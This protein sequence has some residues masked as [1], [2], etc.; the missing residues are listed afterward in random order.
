MRDFLQCT[1]LIT[2]AS[3]G[4]GW[5]MAR[6]LA[7]RAAC[8]ILAARRL[9]R[10]EA[11]KEELLVINPE[12][13]VELHQVDL[14]DAFAL[15]LFTEKLIKSQTNLDFLINN[16]GLG[17]RGPFETSEWEKIDKVLRVNVLALT[18][19]CHQLIPLLKR[20]RPGAIL[21]VSSIA[22]QLPVPDMGVYAATKAYVSSFSETLRAE[23]R[24]T[25]ISVTYVCP[26]PVDTGFNAAATRTPDAPEEA[27]APSWVKVSAER[28]VRD[29]LNGV[30]RDRARVIPG[31]WMMMA[32][33][34]FAILPL[35][36]LRLV[37]HF[38]IQHHHNQQRG[39]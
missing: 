6:Q 20:Y 32:T 33:I 12:L 9:D 22:S 3:S 37:F 39:Q 28:V 13:T 4:L 10:L 36:V 19:L 2:G 21:N 17:D 1:A 8:L 18:A 30:L 15:K 11:L 7:P 14:A 31:F 24:G 26:G 27:P 34:L 35:C 23:L 29:A 16:A 38:Q 25:G 5:E